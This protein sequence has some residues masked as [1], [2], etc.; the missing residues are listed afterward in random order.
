MVPANYCSI[1]TIICILEVTWQQDSKHINKSIICANVSK[2][3]SYCIAVSGVKGIGRKILK[4]LIQTLW[5]VALFQ[6]VKSN[7]SQGNIV[8]ICRIQHRK[9]NGFLFTEMGKR[10]L[11]YRILK[12]ISTSHKGFPNPSL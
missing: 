1:S 5:D 9:N 3:R 2:Y 6:L 10:F 12:I 8:Y 7:Y 4:F 11:L